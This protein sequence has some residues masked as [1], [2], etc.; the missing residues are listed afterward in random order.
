M[1][2]LICSD[3]QLPWSRVERP[4]EHTETQMEVFI[5]DSQL[6]RF[7]T[8]MQKGKLLFSVKNKLVNVAVVAQ[9]FVFMSN[10]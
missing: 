6:Q 3:I 7:H 5:S 10:C 8:L 9:F 4:G 1:P 2:V